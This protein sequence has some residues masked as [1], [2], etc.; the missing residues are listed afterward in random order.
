MR[1]ALTRVQM[2]VLTAM[3][4]AGGSICLCG[5]YKRARF[6]VQTKDGRPAIALSFVV[7]ENLRRKQFI[8]L[9]ENSFYEITAAGRELLKKKRSSKCLIRRRTSL[10]PSTAMP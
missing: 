4:E 10:P 5:G 7:I 6:G 3:A 9:A 1:G 2:L 8:A